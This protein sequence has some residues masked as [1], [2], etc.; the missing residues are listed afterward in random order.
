MTSLAFSDPPGSTAQAM[1]VISSNGP[2]ASSRNCRNLS[3]AQRLRSSAPSPRASV[4]S[5]NSVDFDTGPARDD[6]SSTAQPLGSHRKLSAS[7]HPNNLLV[8]ASWFDERAHLRFCGG[9]G[10]FAVPF[11]SM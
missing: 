8:L 4:S 6:R 9:G 7:G 11:V 5:V 1:A 3:F 2:A 10:Y